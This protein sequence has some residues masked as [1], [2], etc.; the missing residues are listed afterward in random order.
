MN[1]SR[2]HITISPSPPGLQHAY[3]ILFSGEAQDFLTELVNT[4]RNRVDQ[5]YWDRVNR[6]C[7]FHLHRKTP[8][9]LNTKQRHDPT[10]KV[11]PVPPR[12][13]N[14][15]LDLGDV[16][17]ANTQHFLQA[18]N[19]DVQGIQVD[20]DD[21]HCPSWK[22]QIIG[23]YNVYQAVHEEFYGVSDL[24]N[25]P[26]L[27]LRPRAWNMI[28]HNIM[29]DGKETPGPL[30]DFGIIMYH[31]SKILSNK[32]A[33][34]FF[35]LS[36]V[37][38]ASEAKLWNDIFIWTQ[39]RLQIPYGTIKACVLIENILSAFE[40]EEILYELRDHSLGLNCGIW[41]Y[42]A[43]IICK[44]GDDPNYVLPDRNKYVNMQKHFLKKYMQLVIQTCH[45]RGAHA[46]G[47]MAALLVPN[48][49][50]SD[51]LNVI[52]K[53][54]K[55]KEQEILA[56]VDGFMVY[57]VKLVP[58]INK[59]WNTYCANNP[60]QLS[61]P[62]K[63][64]HITERDLL[65]MPTG[66]ITYDGLK[67]NIEVAILF[68]YNWLNGE[69]HFFYKGAVEDSATAEI[70]RS[71]IWQWIKH[72]AIIEDNKET[73]TKELVQNLTNDYIRSRHFKS[74]FIHIAAKLF[75]DIVT[76]RYFPDFITTYLNDNYVFRHQHAENNTVL[77]PKL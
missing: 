59:L 22:N 18:L 24:N 17:P 1:Q 39:Q 54:V 26:I 29:I 74:A 57:D 55:A 9:F 71:Q 11:L 53:V 13:Q 68:I 61:L 45:A 67:H 56:G 42:A 58:C 77:S 28:E 25:I 23:L 40:M 15:K 2:S 75:I 34:P 60:N 49:N 48:E 5:L 69:G 43:S 30:V 51:Q 3:N 37:E 31:N 63:Y 76:M 66:C 41:D 70:S 47:G 19:A 8:E 32:G 73:V 72:K 12:L 52:E 4:F 27:M 64:E 38:G 65:T 16:S 21:G 36:K 10:W 44:F 35:Y 6:K 62:I 46:T 7:Q 50:K 33:G 14:R 20:F